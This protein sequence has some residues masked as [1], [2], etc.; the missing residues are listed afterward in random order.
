[1]NIFQET[2]RN[3]LVSAVIKEDVLGV[4]LALINEEQLGDLSMEIICLPVF[5]II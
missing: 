2:N 3:L 1:M 4:V 5:I